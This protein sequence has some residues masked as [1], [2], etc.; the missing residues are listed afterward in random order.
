MI[1]L[2]R[3][4][5]R[6]LLAAAV[7]A[8]LLL[9]GVVPAG[10]VRRKGETT[11]IELLEEAELV[12]ASACEWIGRGVVGLDLAGNEVEFPAEPFRPIFAMRPSSAMPS[13]RSTSGTCARPTRRLGAALENSTIQSL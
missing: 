3:P 13:S 7:L 6:R 9:Q 1:R 2:W 11:L 12:A 8:A 10:E 4:D 5:R